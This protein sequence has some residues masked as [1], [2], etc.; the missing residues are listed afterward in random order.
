MGVKVNDGMPKCPHSVQYV[1]V[2]DFIDGVM[3][4]CRITL[5]AKFNVAVHPEDH[6]ILDSMF[7]TIAQVILAFWLVLTFDLLED[8][9]RIEVINTKFF[10]LHFKM[11]ESFEK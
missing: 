5:M 8:R 11:A 4:R 7:Y 10:F 6:Y 1:T 2:D 9:C 3:S